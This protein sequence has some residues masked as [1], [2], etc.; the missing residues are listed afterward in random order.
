M[1]EIE[2]SNVNK[3][4]NQGC[5]YLKEAYFKSSKKY[6][7]LKKTIFGKSSRNVQT[8]STKV[9]YQGHFCQ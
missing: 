4:D 1:E 5:L 7:P 2:T 9:S 8:R 6:V 3:Q